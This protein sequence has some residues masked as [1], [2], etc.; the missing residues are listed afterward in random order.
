MRRL[1][2]RTQQGL[3]ALLLLGLPISSFAYF[4][5]AIGGG[6]QV[7]PFALYPLIVLAVFVTLPA[8]FRRRLPLSAAW[9]GLF[10]M[11]AVLA[12][13]LFIFR[14]LP[15]VNGVRP[16]ARVV[17]GFITLVIGAA[18]YLT[19]A[20][21]PK[22]WEDLRRTLRWLY[23]ALAWALA[24]GTFQIGY[25]LTHSYA[26]YLKANRLQRL[27]S[28]RDLMTRRISGPAYEPNWFASQLL[29][30]FLPWLLASVLTGRSLFRWR[31]RWVTVELALTV[32]AFVVLLFTYSRAGLAMAGGM[33]ALAVFLR[34]SKR[35]SMKA[36]LLSL[37]GLGVVAVA[38]LAVLGKINPYFARLWT[39]AGMPLEKYVFM[40]GMQGRFSY[41]QAAYAVYQQHPWL[42]VG[43]GNFAFYFAHAVHPK[44]LG[45][46][47]TELLKVLLP[48][49]GY[50]LVTPKNLYVRLLAETGLVGF[51]AFMAFWQGVF[52]EGVRLFVSG[53][54]ESFWGLGAILGFAALLLY[55]LSFG[56]FA[57]ASM[58]V[59]LGLVTAAALVA[60]GSR[61]AALEDKDAQ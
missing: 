53:G 51:V 28:S 41:W 4:P 45:G 33:L 24:W 60:W 11:V 40:L 27:I 16:P 58:W 30:V 20:L 18:F 17:R 1:W 7:R 36:R 46:L 2:V 57:V 8:L 50:G 31:W 43:L 6:A 5:K 39:A 42:G 47:D 32:W 10:V 34:P 56:S 19:V 44:P 35:F 48:G 52:R 3:W 14:D 12:S 25:V 15:P 54:E 21:F 38:A 26:W 37:A 22:S 9:L 13:A 55:G 23:A 59:F 49:S 29:L 61:E